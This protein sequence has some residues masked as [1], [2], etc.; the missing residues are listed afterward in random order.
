MNVRFPKTTI[1]NLIYPTTLIFISISTYLI[2]KLGPTPF[3]DYNNVFVNIKELALVEK[4]DRYILFSWLFILIFYAIFLLTKNK[5]F[6]RK[7]NSSIIVYLLILVAIFLTFLSALWTEDLH[8]KMTGI[9]L[10]SGIS[11]IH[12]TMG[13][14]FS[15]VLLLGFS[16]YRPLVNRFMNLLLISISFFYILPNIIQFP[17]YL[18]D[19][20]HFN[21][22]AND[23][24]ANSIGK[25]VFFDYFPVYTNLLGIPL[26]PVLNFSPNHP[27]QLAVYY[28]LLL[29]AIILFISFLLIKATAPKRLIPLSF[30]ILILPIFATG[31]IGRSPSSYLPLFPLRIVIPLICIYLSLRVLFSNH[32][33]KYGLFSLGVFLGIN[34]F[35]NLEF[36]LTS[37]LS[38]FISSLILLRKSTNFST[39]IIVVLGG[40]VSVFISIYSFFELINKPLKFEEIFLFIKLTLS[41]FYAV[42]MDAFGIHLIIVAL[43]ITGCVISANQLLRV[44][45]INSKILKRNY[46]LLVIS[47]WSVMALPYFVGRSF[48]ATIIGGFGFHY[49]LIITLFLPTIFGVF[50]ITRSQ[51]SYLFVNSIFGLLGLSIILSL[52][53]NINNPRFKIEQFKDFKAE[54]SDFLSLR[55]QLEYLLEDSYDKT[56]SDL[57]KSNSISQIL[58]LS[59]ALESQIGFPSELVTNHPWHLE[60]TPLYTTLQCEYSKES[61]YRYVLTNPRIVDSLALNPACS[62][63]FDFENVKALTEIETNLVIIPKF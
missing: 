16:N 35:N 63:V 43:F 6:S 10:W 61:K 45:I 4:R 9:S 50:R 46:L 14:I 52:S 15:T 5:Y 33:T 36:G 48:P 41:G 56:F 24:I 44:P 47:L 20:N 27:V 28:L 21:F 60:V 57:I 58:P 26:A 49:A 62:N 53:F 31:D 54:S 22:I 3:I 55:L 34:I 25:T 42:P 37:S 13:V 18:D 23:L 32:I 30:L 19:Q 38:I 40:I 51:V 1:L 11:P 7:F 8:E 39:F 59:A 17:K 2:R 29:Q 12:I